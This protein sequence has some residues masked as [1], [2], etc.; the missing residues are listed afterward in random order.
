MKIDLARLSEERPTILTASWNAEAQDV[1]GPGIRFV[2]PLLIRVEAR[3]DSGLALLEVSVQSKMRLTCAR[4]Y[5]DFTEDL[6]KAFKLAYSLDMEE[7]VVDI[8]EDIREE[9]ILGFSQKI[10][11]RQDCKGLC[12]RCGADLNKGACLCKR[13]E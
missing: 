12:P 4:C 6:D 13:D 5:E 2:E 9:L 11:C 8:D 1:N 10:L 3:R 7:T